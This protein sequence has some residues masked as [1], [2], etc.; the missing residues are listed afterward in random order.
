MA[1][2]EERL[3]QFE[4]VKAPEPDVTVQVLCEDHSGT[5]LLPF[6]CSFAAGKWRNAVSGELIEAQVVGWREPS[7]GLSRWA[8]GEGN[9]RQG[10]A[11][12]KSVMQFNLLREATLSVRVANVA[13]TI[14]THI[15]CWLGPNSYFSTR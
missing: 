6:H 2:R 12:E 9:Y 11:T 7:A 14:R 4:V 10:T 8:E 15:C 1:T 5:Y 3:A 13:Q